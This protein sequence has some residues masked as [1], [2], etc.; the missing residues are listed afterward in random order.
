[1][2]LIT[3]KGLWNFKRL[4]GSSEKTRLKHGFVSKSPGFVDDSLPKM[5]EFPTSH[6]FS[7]FKIGGLRGSIDPIWAS[8]LEHQNHPKSHGFEKSCSQWP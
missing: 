7:V 1:M 3:S 6:G 4:G 8:K 5:L 2:E